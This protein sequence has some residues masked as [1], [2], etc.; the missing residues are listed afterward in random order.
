VKCNFAVGIAMLVDN[1]LLII[2]QSN[3][4]SLQLGIYDDIG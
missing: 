4:Y 3:P 1:P 2:I